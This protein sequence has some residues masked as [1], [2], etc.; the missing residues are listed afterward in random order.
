[1][2]TQ[3]PGDTDT[4]TRAGLAPPAW[5]GEVASV[6]YDGT[7]GD[8]RIGGPV[9]APGGVRPSDTTTIA[10]RDQRVTAPKASLH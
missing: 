1:M 3:R 2:A 6:G 10:P 8:K 4:T 9:R 5:P 7:R